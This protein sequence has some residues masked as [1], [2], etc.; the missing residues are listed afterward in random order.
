[1]GYFKSEYL[2]KQSLWPKKCDNCDLLFVDKPECQLNQT[3]EYKVCAKS[4]V[5]L[6]KNGADSRHSCVFGLCKE[7]KYEILGASPSRKRKR[8]IIQD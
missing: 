2:E 1:M 7:C 8:R 4:P 3:I 5:F 6:C